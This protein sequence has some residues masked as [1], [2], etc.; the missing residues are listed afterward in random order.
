MT[1][2]LATY[3]RDHLSGS[4]FAVELLEWLRDQHPQKHLGE[5]AAGMLSEIE[6]DRHVLEDALA[7]MDDGAPLVREAASWVA[8]KRKGCGAHR[9]ACQ[10]LL[11]AALRFAR[12]PQ[13]AAEF[14]LRP[15]PFGTFE[16]LDLLALSI[17][18]K[19]KIWEAMAKIAQKDNRIRGIDFNKLAARA[20]LQHVQ[21]E[22]RRL[23]AIQ[24]AF[25][26]VAEP[27]AP[28]PG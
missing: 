2:R 4:C 10:D 8:G 21:V 27:H 15:G 20:R 26:G 5:F 22:E 16:A 24:Y 19:L 3:I 6:D 7:R 9:H 23:E 13:E 12:L 18:G 14:K 1:D 17:L 25:A 28:I 11:R